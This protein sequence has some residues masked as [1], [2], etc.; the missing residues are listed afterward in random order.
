MQVPSLCTVIITIR[1]HICVDCSCI[2]FDNFLKRP[3]VCCQ[4][5]NTQATLVGEME[6]AAVSRTI[7]VGRCRLTL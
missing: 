3:S 4:L 2:V 7:E 1:H 6:A 5:M